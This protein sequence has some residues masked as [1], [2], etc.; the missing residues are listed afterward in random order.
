MGFYY[1]LAALVFRALQTPS[2]APV[3]SSQRKPYVAS[4]GVLLATFVRL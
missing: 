4:V 3:A 1:R 2:G